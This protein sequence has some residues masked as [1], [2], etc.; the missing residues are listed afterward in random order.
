MLVGVLFAVHLHTAKGDIK[1]V[2]VPTD[3]IPMAFSQVPNN[4][5]IC[6]RAT[7]ILDFQ[8]LLEERATPA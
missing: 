5:G 4:L 6:V 2:A 7:R 3:N 8:K 1:I